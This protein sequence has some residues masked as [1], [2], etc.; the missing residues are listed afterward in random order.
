MSIISCSS[1]IRCNEILNTIRPIIESEEGE[2]PLDIL[3]L[4][5]PI[6]HISDTSNLYTD[7]TEK[8][9]KKQKVVDFDILVTTTN[10]LLFLLQNKC[11][12]GLRQQ[13]SI[14]NLVIDKIDL[15]LAMDLEDELKQCG[16]KIQ[17]LFDHN[18]ESE[19]PTKIVLT[20]NEQEK[21][22]NF[23]EIKT[24]FMKEQKA[25]IIKLKEQTKSTSRYE[26]V[27]HLAVE[28]DSELQK[29]LIFYTLI[30][31][32]VLSGRTLVFV[33]TLYEAYKVKVFLEKF[34]IRSAIVNPESTKV[35]RKSAIRY[36]HAGQYDMLILIR[37]KYSYK[38][39]TSNIVN[40]VN[41][42]TP[43]NIQDYSLAAKKLNFD[44]ASVL[45]FTYSESAKVHENKE[46]KYMESLTKKMLKKYGRS[47]FVHLPI[48]WTEVNKL[49]SRVD[50]ILC[51]L[52]NK[53]IKQYMGNEIKKQILTS[54]KLKDYFQ[55][56]EEEKD[57]LKS[58]IDSGYK[59]RYMNKNLDFVPDY[60]MPNAIIK[61]A[62]E[63]KIEGD[64][65][66]QDVAEHVQ[67]LTHDLLIVQKLNNLP[68]P[69]QTKKTLHYEEPD[70]ID[71]E[72]LEFTAGRKLWKLQHKKRVKKG[73]KKAKDG[74]M[75]S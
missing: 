66:H 41:F 21:E 10:N 32:N 48:N 26:S 33:D 1:K 22:E 25:V 73:L 62:I 46:H 13:I 20:T 18:V 40:I 31:F 65:V 58:S 23:S 60:L 36:F 8:G 16:E 56:H 64:T 71:P 72:Q 11:F 42:T 30:K 74:Y 24:A 7:K 44:N 38:L 37:M 67:G 61:S 47:L 49:K 68:K 6:E 9:A 75:G 17:S 59:Y 43:Q 29:Y 53:K 57:I 50:D 34:A 28:C 12:E 27:G 14:S 55:E 15:H 70:N 4:D 19:F 35:A 39:K 54:K 63:Q 51:T 69:R 5:H 45:T 2:S 52:T 3:C